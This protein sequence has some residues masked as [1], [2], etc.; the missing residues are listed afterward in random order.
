[1]NENRGA[2]E[3]ARD[4]AFDWKEWSVFAEGD[5]VCGELTID[6]TF[7]VGSD[8]TGVT[9]DKQQIDKATTVAANFLKD[10]E[11]SRPPM[12]ITD[13][14]SITDFQ[15]KLYRIHF[16]LAW[17]WFGLHLATFLLFVGHFQ[18]ILR[19]S[20]FYFFTLIVFVSDLYMRSTI[21]GRSIIAGRNRINQALI[22][23]LC[24]LLVQTV[25]ALFMENAE[26][27]L[28][29][30]M[31]VF[32]KPVV[33]FYLSQRARDA[34]EALIRTT[35]VL[36]R[37][38][39]IEMFLILAFASVACRMFSK[40]ENFYTLGISWLSLFKCR[41]TCLF[42]EWTKETLLDVEDSTF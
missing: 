1:M 23:Y 39:F 34:L 17:K 36:S 7:S 37:V 18:S 10:Y 3:D 29:I 33:L 26:T 20:V 21:K 25:A 11:A 15:L 40:Y 12:L 22:L 2:N 6:R 35:K 32:F 27:N 16:S 31:A 14:H 28:F 4:N 38:V 9:I 42:F 41:S 5:G 13:F 8:F 24:I 30:L 19:T